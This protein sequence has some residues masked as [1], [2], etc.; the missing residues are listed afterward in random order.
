MSCEGE[1]APDRAALA[2]ILAAEP[3]PEGRPKGDLMG[4]PEGSP[5][6]ELAVGEA[7]GC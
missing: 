7:E 2:D 5:G 4:G 1:P 6:E 3:S